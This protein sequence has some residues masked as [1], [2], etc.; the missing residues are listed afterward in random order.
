MTFS[1]GQ[2]EPAFLPADWRAFGAYGSLWMSEEEWSGLAAEVA[3]VPRPAP[4]WPT[5]V[6]EVGNETPLK[7]VRLFVRLIVKPCPEG[8]VITMGDHVAAAVVV[9]AAAGFN[10]AQVAVEPVVT[11]APAQL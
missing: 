6:S 9:A 3:V 10:R 1:G 11:V 8:T 7:N 2:F 4:N 5:I